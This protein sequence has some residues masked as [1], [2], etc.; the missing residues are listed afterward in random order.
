MSQ[1]VIAFS[2]TGQDYILV[3]G[4]PDQV[5]TAL[6]NSKRTVSGLCQL[7]DARGGDRPPVYVNP[8]QVA[9]VRGV[10]DD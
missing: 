5:N 3:E 6:S 4:T 8:D 10:A 1:S 9:Y 2:G 7:T